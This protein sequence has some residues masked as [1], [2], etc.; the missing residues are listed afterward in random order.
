MKTAATGAVAI[1]VTWKSGKTTEEWFPAAEYIPAWLQ[2]EAP[3][4]ENFEW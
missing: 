4:I 3:N 2:L 1:Q